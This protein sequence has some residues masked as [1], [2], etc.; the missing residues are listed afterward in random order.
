MPWILGVRTPQQQVSSLHTIAGLLHRAARLF[1][2]A[3]LQSAQMRYIRPDLQ[4]RTVMAAPLGHLYEPRCQ[5]CNLRSP[6][7]SE[8]SNGIPKRWA[9]LS[10]YAHNSRSMGNDRNRQPITGSMTLTVRTHVCL[11]NMLFTAVHSPAGKTAW[12]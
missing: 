6:H 8:Y 4:P 7:L 5:M 2:A 10:Q 12:R 9:R 1:L 3:K 11:C